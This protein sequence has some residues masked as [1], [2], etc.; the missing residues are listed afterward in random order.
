M[1]TWLQNFI[2]K[3]GKWFF[4]LLL[5]VVIVSFVPYIS[6]TG[7]SSLDF[8]P[9]CS[10]NSQLEKDDFYGQNW[11][12]PRVYNA[13][14]VKSQVSGFFGTSPQPSQYAQFE[15][16]RK[17]YE[18]KI[19]DSNEQERLSV[20]LFMETKIA[21]L[22][23]ADTWG[24]PSFASSSEAMEQTLRSFILE[25]IQAR[26]SDPGEFD[27]AKYEQAIKQIATP[28]KMKPSE[29]KE[30]LFDDFRADQVDK[31]LRGGGFALPVEAKID[32]RENDLLWTFEAVS[33]DKESFQPDP[34]PFA[35][36]QFNGLPEPGTTLGLKYEDAS[37]TFTFLE[38]SPQKD[39]NGSNLVVLLGTGETK[40]DKI[41]A[42]RDNLVNALDKTGLEFEVHPVEGNASSASVG[43][44]L[45]LPS[46]G[47]PSV[48]PDVNASTDL[49]SISNELDDE[50][51]QYFEERA[52]EFMEPA[53]TGITILEF[54]N[55]D[56]FDPP[57]VPSEQAIR[58]H[59]ELHKDEFT[60]P[61]PIP[62][63]APKPTPAPEIKQSEKLPKLEKEGEQGPLGKPGESVRK[64]RVPK[65]EE[66][67]EE[68]PSQQ[69]GKPVPA[70]P[71][72]KKESPKEPSK[73]GP[74]PVQPS[75]PDPAT[76]VPKS[77]TPVDSN[78]QDQ[79]ASNLNKPVTSK[80]DG[81]SPIARVPLTFEEARTQIIERL[82]E[83]DR[84]VEEKKAAG[85]AKAKAT[86]FIDDLHALSKKLVAGGSDPLKARQDDQVTNLIKRYQLKE[87]PVFFT[88]E[89]IDT[90]SLLFGLDPKAL[91]DML[92]LSPRR[93]H[94]EAKY[95]TRQ[96]IAVLLLDA[97]IEPQPMRYED[98][99]KKNTFREFLGNFRTNR[100]NKAFQELGDEIA[101]SLTKS[102][103][104]GGALE[105]ISEKVDSRLSYHTFEATNESSLRRDFTKRGNQL[106]IR[107]TNAQQKL[108]NL[109]ESVGDRNATDSE[110]AQIEQQEALIKELQD[111]Q[112]EINNDNTLASELFEHAKD[113]TTKVGELTQ[114]VTGA[115]SDSGIFVFLKE[116]IL[117]IDPE[118][119]ALVEDLLNNMEQ[120]RSSLSRE[121]I[122]RDWISKGRSNL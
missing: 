108:N 59:W 55:S 106:L 51:R 44:A 66:A 81:Q 65:K 73:K 82:L 105:E 97:R 15:I 43:L 87:H 90:Y 60:K 46:E 30:F 100:K 64:S 34:V 9:G 95:A 2:E 27:A 49:L 8:F 99:L 109:K 6:P 85:K 121:N 4:I 80:P 5:L 25:K 113:S 52:G 84:A 110:T 118:E 72:D 74:E 16:Q 13:L 101:K 42:T 57:P 38:A 45:S 70:A 20:K 67:P 78:A 56:Y 98:Q 28:L 115:Q 39:A 62:A 71:E 12:D 22:Q 77:V 92:K 24:L 3:R 54:A 89:E 69:K 33:I 111:N 119:S 103:E 17:I 63:P 79:N 88:D 104:E 102:L 117:E 116:I 41:A 47:A 1:I 91:N 23:A 68:K 21:L 37:L 7:E 19:S 50:L 10:A 96:G 86:Q 53:Q 76:N 29:V 40:D 26:L 75:K 107:Q 120:R 14:R 58:A 32:L 112:V 31:V 18:E 61:A 83:A 93:F 48:M 36:I 94:S 11:N 122:L 35:R 114:M